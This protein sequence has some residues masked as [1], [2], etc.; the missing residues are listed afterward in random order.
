MSNEDGMG[1]TV[2]DELEEAIR[3]NDFQGALRML[4]GLK[5]F[6]SDSPEIMLLQAKCYVGLGRPLSALSLLKNLAVDESQ[7]T[8][9]LELL[10]VVYETL[11]LDDWAIETTRRLIETGEASEET[12][13]SLAGLLLGKGSAGEA[14]AAARQGLDIFPSSESLKHSLGLCYVHQN[15]RERANEI[16]KELE[17]QGSSFAQDLAAALEQDDRELQDEKKDQLHQEAQEHLLKAMEYMSK[18]EV[19]GAV[20]DLIIGLRKAP[21]LAIAYTRLGYLYDSIGLIEEGFSLHKKALEIDPNLAEAHANIGYGLQ[22]RGSLKEAI[23]AF[24]KALE[25]D[26]Q[27]V[28]A[29]NSI[30]V[31]YDNLGKYDKGIEHFQAAL[32]VNPKHASTLINLGFAYRTLGKFDEAIPILENAV[33]LRSDFATR[34][35]LASAYRQGGRLEDARALLTSLAEADSESLTVALELAL[36]H[37]DLGDSEGFRDA[38]GKVASLKPGKPGEHFKKA[39]VMEL[40]DKQ[41]ALECWKEYVTFAGHPS[42]QGETVSYAK[43]RIDSLESW[44]K[45]GGPFFLD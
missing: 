28:E 38:A 25:L 15:E 12:Y 1:K 29:H 18:G 7:E 41:L 37:N 11:L 4:Q 16:L 30:G 36:C 5:S 32:D 8:S 19:E 26:P 34:F 17:S 20:R 40:F 22:K 24:E 27:N 42:V 45:E 10:R 43:G 33:A 39:Q 2:M 23:A 13:C 14:V 3:N 6:M 9:R 21:T 31:L 35:M 44:L